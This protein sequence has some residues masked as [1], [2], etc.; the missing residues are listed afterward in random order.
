MKN[1]IAWIVVWL[2]AML[3]QH[4]LDEVLRQVVKKALPGHHIRRSRK[5]LSIEVVETVTV[6]AYET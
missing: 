6:A 3:N 4:D 2:L 1:V 5:T